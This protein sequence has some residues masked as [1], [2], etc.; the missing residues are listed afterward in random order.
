MQTVLRSCKDGRS[1]SV[2]SIATD[3]SELQYI[4]VDKGLQWLL[5][6]TFVARLPLKHVFIGLTVCRSFLHQPLHLIGQ[7]FSNEL[8][9]LVVSK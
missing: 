2:G 4:C 7:K 1:D 6:A 5:I 8:P 9:R 3:V